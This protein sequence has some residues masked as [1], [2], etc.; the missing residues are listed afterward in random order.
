MG[1]SCQDWTS[2]DGIGIET[3]GLRAKSDDELDAL[4]GQEQALGPASALF[5]A[6]Q[7]K[8]VLEVKA[9]SVRNPDGEVLHK[10]STGW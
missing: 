7:G 3:R 8:H 2:R 10:S 5:M 9:G 6:G 4:R 1:G